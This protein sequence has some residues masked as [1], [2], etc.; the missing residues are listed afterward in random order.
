MPK[1]TEQKAKTFFAPPNPKKLNNKEN[2]ELGLGIGKHTK[3]NIAKDEKHNSEIAIDRIKST[4]KRSQKFDNLYNL[5]EDVLEEEKINEALS[6][7]VLL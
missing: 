5:E 1:K 2:D 7:V 3:F 4:L 6:N